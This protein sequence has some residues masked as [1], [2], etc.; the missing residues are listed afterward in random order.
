MYTRK[1]LCVFNSINCMAILVTTDLWLYSSQIRVN[2]IKS[3]K[4]WSF[5]ELSSTHRKMCSS[6]IL[7]RSPTWAYLGLNLELNSDMPQLIA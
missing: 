6:A 5:E 1:V 3:L 4:T 2:F 7:C